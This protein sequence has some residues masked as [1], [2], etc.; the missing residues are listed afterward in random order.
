[1]IMNIYSHRAINTGRIDANTNELLITNVIS[2]KPI[3]DLPDVISGTVTR[4]LNTEDTLEFTYPTSGKN[5]SQL[6]LR[7]I[8][9]VK[10]D[11]YRQTQYFRIQTID[12]DI[13]GVITIYAIHIVYDLIDH[14]SPI[15]FSLVPGANDKYT[16]QSITKQ[17][18]N[19]YLYPFIARDF[20]SDASSYQRIYSSGYFKYD[21]SHIKIPDDFFENYGFNGVITFREAIISDDV[22]LLNFLGGEMEFDR[23]IIKHRGHI[24]SS[25]GFRI[26]QGVNMTGFNYNRSCENIYSDIMPYWKGSFH[27]NNTLYDEYVRK[28]C[29]PTDKTTEHIKFMGYDFNLYPYIDTDVINYVSRNLI[30]VYYR[31]SDGNKKRC[32]YTKIL[33]VDITDIYNSLYGI[34]DGTTLTKQPSRV[35]VATCG[36]LYILSNDLGNPTVSMSVDFA[37]LSKSS[38]FEEYKDLNKLMLGDTVQIV[39]SM[40]GVVG[41]AECTSTKYNIVTDMYDSLELGTPE[42]KFVETFVKA[43][44]KKKHYKTY[45]K[46]PTTR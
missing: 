42:V 36:I 41:E 1:M 28:L 45:Y 5:S 18:N 11:P 43:T 33:P 35:D 38:E 29:I 21:G 24:G 8:V 12:K 25:K 31:D 23:Y 13:D 32:V 6:A 46:K 16:M 4:A 37:D 15:G 10:A 40:A 26:D 39:N 34:E 30:P 9:E 22:S 3:C 44:K 14:C 17:V 19:D 2:E 27:E 20:N 7:R